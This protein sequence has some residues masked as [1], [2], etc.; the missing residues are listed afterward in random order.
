MLLERDLNLNLSRKEFEI[1]TWFMQFMRMYVNTTYM[2]RE[3]I[4]ICLHMC[5]FDYSLLQVKATS[6]PLLEDITV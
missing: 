3:A 4:Y 6:Y 5:I 1:H 2:H